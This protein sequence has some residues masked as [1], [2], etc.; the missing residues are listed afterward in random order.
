M[1]LSL[2][3]VLKNHAK[4]IL[5]PVDAATLAM[6]DTGH[7]FEQYVEALFPD[8]VTLGFNNYDEYLSLP[9][10]TTDALENGATTIFQGRFEYEKLIVSGLT[11][12]NLSA[13]H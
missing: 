5:P 2:K 12:I 6:F 1:K 4:T 10:R 7:E 8:A 9:E 13:K 3:Y 11:T